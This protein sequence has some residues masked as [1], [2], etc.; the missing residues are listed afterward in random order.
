MRCPPDRLT[1]NL[2]AE[3]GNP[4]DFEELYE[5]VKNWLPRWAD[6]FGVTKFPSVQLDYVNLLGPAT[7]P[8]FVD[9]NGGIRINRLL[10]V[11]GKIP[12]PHKTIIAPYDCKVGL[13]I[14]PNRCVANIHVQGVRSKEGTLHVRVDLQV[15]AKQPDPLAGIDQALSELH[16]IHE[17]LLSQFLAIFTEEAK[18]SFKP[19]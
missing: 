2:H 10:E 16:Y 5:A 12:G 19:L 6:H 14:E 7:T 18:Q 15:L 13:L 1:L 11:F 9:K 8:T 4:H 17:I 3:T